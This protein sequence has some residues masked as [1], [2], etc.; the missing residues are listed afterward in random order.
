[1]LTVIFLFHLKKPNFLALNGRF[2][3]DKYVFV[4]M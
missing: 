4:L 3:N 2:I 1:L